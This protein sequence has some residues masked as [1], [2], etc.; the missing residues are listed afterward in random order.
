MRDDPPTYASDKYVPIEPSISIRQ[1]NSLFH[2]KPI[3]RSCLLVLLHPASVWT[4]SL[5]KA[6]GECKREHRIKQGFA[7]DSVVVLFIG[8]IYKI[9]VQ[10]LKSI[11]CWLPRHQARHESGQTS[12][13]PS[14]FPELRSSASL[15]LLLLPAT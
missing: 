3:L 5:A 11:K 9:L 2:S 6:I 13:F 12:S 1:T 15:V 10:A 8:H 4:I 7:P 14:L